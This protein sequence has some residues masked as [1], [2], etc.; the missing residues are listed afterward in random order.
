MGPRPEARHIST[1][2][3][4]GRQS[5]LQ[6]RRGV[7]RRRDAVHRDGQTGRDLGLRHDHRSVSTL[8]ATDKVLAS[9]I[10]PR[11]TTAIGTRRIFLRGIVVMTEILRGRSVG[12]GLAFLGLGVHVG[13]RGGIGV[14]MLFDGGLLLVIVDMLRVIDFLVLVNMV[15][16]VT[17]RVVQAFGLGEFVMSH[18]VAV[19]GS[20]CIAMFG[21]VTERLAWQHFRVHCNGHRRGRR[22][23]MPVP[24]IIIFQIFENVA[25]VQERVAVKPDVH[26]SGLH[27]RKHSC[28]AAFVDTAD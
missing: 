1:A 14:V 16:V 3:N 10:A 13:M 5:D 24:V 7:H 22:L 8:I 6:V 20:M 19:L 28:Y 12:F 26:E 27:A 2:A 9:T 11:R 15:L 4:C 23:R 17:M 18:V 21:G 25:D